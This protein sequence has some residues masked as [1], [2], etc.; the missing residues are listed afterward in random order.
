MLREARGGL[1]ATVGNRVTTYH[2]ID[3]FFCSFLFLSVRILFSPVGYA[4][5]HANMQILD[6]AGLI[7]AEV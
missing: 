3:I 2:F 6:V 4:Q 5:K 1:R 7:Q